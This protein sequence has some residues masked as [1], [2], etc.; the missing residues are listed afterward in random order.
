MTGTASPIAELIAAVE[1]ADSSDRLVD[2]VRALAESADADAASTL[3]AV[4]GYNN[5]GA[6]VAAV[7][8]LI[9]LGDMVVS[10]LMARL[11][12]YDYGARAWAI[13]ALSGIGN[14]H[15]LDLLIEAAGGDFSLSVRR[16]AARGLG[17]VRWEL[18]PAEAIAAAQT[19]A[20]EALWQVCEDP[21]WVVR[22]AAIVG[23]EGLAACQPTLQD[24]IG[25]RLHQRLAAETEVAVC[26]RIRWALSQQAAS[27]EVEGAGQH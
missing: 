2:A 25:D 19:Q 17:Y 14:P 11:D 21:E 27:P 24:R 3:I 13:R 23:L 9:A 26:A 15:A 8:G 10:E 12:G 6:A 16:A 20:L 22:Y 7:E 4:L 1:R 18:L 5:P